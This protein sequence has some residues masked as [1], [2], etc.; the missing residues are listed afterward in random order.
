MRLK[1]IIAAYT[2]TRSI[3]LHKFYI[4]RYYWRG[5]HMAFGILSFSRRIFPVDIGKNF[6][7]FSNKFFWT[8][9]ATADRRDPLLARVLLEARIRFD[10]I[11]KLVRNEFTFF[12][13]FCKLFPSCTGIVLFVFRNIPLFW[14]FNISVLH[15]MSRKA[16]HDWLKFKCRSSVFDTARKKYVNPNAL[17][18][19]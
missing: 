7:F 17:N 6:I 2:H 18:V 8:L 5:Q 14:S 19:K 15:R 16:G 9:K 12:S 13:F 3:I 10:S 1:N 4:A 11:R